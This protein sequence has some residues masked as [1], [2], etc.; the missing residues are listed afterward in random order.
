M[1]AKYRLKNREL[2]K[3]LEAIGGKNN[4]RKAIDEFLEADGGVMFAFDVNDKCRVTI[5]I[6]RDELEVCPSYNPNDWNFYPEVTPPEGVWMRTEFID[7][8]VGTI[9]TRC[10]QYKEKN[11]NCY[12]TYD[13]IH[14]F[15][16]TRY[17]SL[18]DMGLE[19]FRA[20][21]TN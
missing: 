7:K 8:S 4:V 9:T 16:V 11:G 5:G 6:T 14:A 1:T 19:C 18:D 15:D 21:S 17:R 12:W 10:G 2:Q 3:K 13:G 20:S